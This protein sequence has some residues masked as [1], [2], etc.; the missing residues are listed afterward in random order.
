MVEKVGWT[1]SYMRLKY[2]KK[3]FRKNGNLRMD[4][5]KRAKKEAEK[6]YKVHK[7]KNGL[8]K[9]RALTEAINFKS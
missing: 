7:T 5:L 6:E 9:L 8:F 3:A 2:G 1:R 4:Y